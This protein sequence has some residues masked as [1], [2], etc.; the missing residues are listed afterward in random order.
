MANPGDVNLAP[1]SESPDGLPI[2]V[3]GTVVGTPTVVHKHGGG[4]AT[5]D[6]VTIVLCNTHATTTQSVTVVCYVGGGTPTDPASVIWRGDVPAGS[7]AWVA[8]SGKSVTNGK[9]VAVF[10]ANASVV[11]VDGKVS[12]TTL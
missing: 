2:A 1:L 11:N 5:V 9:W 3:T 12:R 10:C 6:Q 7:G 4:S 8:I